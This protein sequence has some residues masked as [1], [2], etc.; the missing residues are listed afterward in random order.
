MYSE[1]II[2][3]ILNHQRDVKITQVCVF[4]TLHGEHKFRWMI[5]FLLLAG[6]QPQP[7]AEETE[8]TISEKAETTRKDMGK[9]PWVL[10]IEKDTLDNHYYREVKWTGEYMQ[11]VLMSLK[12]GEVIDLELHE[13]IDQFIRIEQGEARVMMGETKE[14][15]LFDK[16]VS[17]DWAIFIPAGYWHEIRNVG[18]TDLKLYS[19]YSPTEHPAGIRHETYEEAEAYEHEH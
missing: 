10:N 13:D 9:K 2:V 3:H 15:L 12:P 16:T 18:E 8:T 19:I 7:E 6:C 11:M 4:G 5:L 1:T 17:D 14:S